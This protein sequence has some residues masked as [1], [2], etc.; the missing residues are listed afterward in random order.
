MRVNGD[1]VEMSLRIPSGQGAPMAP[2]DYQCR[3][4]GSP[5]GIL[6]AL[7]GRPYGRTSCC[8]YPMYQSNYPW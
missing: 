4:T 7:T 8:Y 1:I 6:P 2:T 3:F 5:R